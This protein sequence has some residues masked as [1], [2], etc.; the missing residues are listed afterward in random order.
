[1]IFVCI[2][3]GQKKRTGP[4][5][6][7]TAGTLLTGLQKLTQNRPT[8]LMGFQ[9]KVTPDMMCLYKNRCAIVNYRLDNS[10]VAAEPLVMDG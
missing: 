5:P 6:I 9:T 10:Q 1:M 3:V 8:T 4:T 2:L 7:I